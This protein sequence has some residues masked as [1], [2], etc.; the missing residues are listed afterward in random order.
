M[1]DS[2]LEQNTILGFTGGT[3]YPDVL[4]L[5]KVQKTLNQKWLGVFAF[6][7]ASSI[8]ADSCSPEMVDS[9]SKIKK[10]RAYRPVAG[11]INSLLMHNNVQVRLGGFCQIP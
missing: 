4:R 7:G 1:Q 10:E 11:F 8:R 2:F 9:G 3:R 5:L 6:E